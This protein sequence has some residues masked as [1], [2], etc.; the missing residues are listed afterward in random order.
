MM[1]KSHLFILHIYFYLFFYF[2]R[3]L[4]YVEYK[5]WIRIVR[6]DLIYDGKCFTVG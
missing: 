3:L 1:M 5:W 6:T 2:S 4:E